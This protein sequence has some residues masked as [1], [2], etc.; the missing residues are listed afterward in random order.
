MHRRVPTSPSSSPLVLGIPPPGS[1][2]NLPYL[3]RSCDM[4]AALPFP[5]DRIFPDPYLLCRSPM[6]CHPVF[7]QRSSRNLPPALPALDLSF[8]SLSVGGTLSR[9]LSH[10][11]R[12]QLGPHRLAWFSY[13]ADCLPDIS[14]QAHPIKQAN[15]GNKY[16]LEPSW[17]RRCNHSIFRIEEGI[18][19]DISHILLQKTMKII[20]AYFSKASLIQPQHTF[21]D[22][23]KEIELL[24][25]PTTTSP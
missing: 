5:C 3:G 1:S 8:L 4:S 19:M 24:Y 17:V 16:T 10:V 9:H 11:C 21:A 23:D 14:P 25:Q 6:L 15:Q 18:L 7:W 22:I 13:H 20:S 2:T 12:L